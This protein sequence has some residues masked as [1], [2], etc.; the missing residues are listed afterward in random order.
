ME[1]I[2]RVRTEVGHEAVLEFPSVAVTLTETGATV[3]LRVKTVLSRE[4]EG[5]PQL[6]EA[7]ETGVV[8]RTVEEKGATERVTLIEGRH[9]MEGLTLSGLHSQA[10]PT[11][12]WS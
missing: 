12:S 11:P 3:S 4:R 6:S 5:A 2:I 9:S 1:P 8:G 7:E 10:S